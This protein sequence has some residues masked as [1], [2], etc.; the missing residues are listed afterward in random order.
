MPV[1]Y[2]HHMVLRWIV[3]TGYL[4]F[5]HAALVRRVLVQSLAYDYP[6]YIR[7]E[8]IATMDAQFVAHSIGAIFWYRKGTHPLKLFTCLGLN[9]VTQPQLD[10]GIAIAFSEIGN[11]VREMKGEN[12]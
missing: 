8:G 2:E 4:R 9:T 7:F 10:A 5:E 1:D 3:G 6:R 12:V 11:L